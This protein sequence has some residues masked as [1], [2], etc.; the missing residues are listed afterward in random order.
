[1]VAYTDNHPKK[2]LADAADSIRPYLEDLEDEYE[3]SDK[4]AKTTAAYEKERDL[5]LQLT[6][7]L[8][9]LYSKYDKETEG[10]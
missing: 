7:E 4:T 9:K 5:A 3:A 1:M 8:V 6:K 10:V 2:V